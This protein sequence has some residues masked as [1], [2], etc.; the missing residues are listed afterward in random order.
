MMKEYI[1]TFFTHFDA[2]CF[3]KAFRKE[4]IEVALAPVPRAVSSSC[5]T[6]AFFATKNALPDLSSFEYEQLFLLENGAY[7]SL[8]DNREIN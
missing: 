1:L 2:I 4:N 3:A 6:S 5:G 7:I 8:Q